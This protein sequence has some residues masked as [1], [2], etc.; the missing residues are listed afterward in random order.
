MGGNQWY[1]RCW[2]VLDRRLKDARR[3]TTMLRVLLVAAFV[4]LILLLLRTVIGHSQPE[5]VISPQQ[6]FGGNVDT[7]ALPTAVISALGVY[8]NKND[9]A[10]SDVVLVTAANFAYLDILRN[11]QCAVKRL[12]LKYVVIAMDKEIYD[13]LGPETAVMM[14]GAQV[15]GVRQ[16]S[17][18]KIASVHKLL[19]AGVDVLFSDPDNVLLQDPFR[20]GAEVGDFIRGGRIDYVYQANLGDSNHFWHAQWVSAYQAVQRL[21][22]CEQQAEEE[23]NTGFYYAR[24]S[25]KVLKAVFRS[26]MDRCVAQPTISDQTHFWNALNDK[27]IESKHCKKREVGGPWFLGLD[28]KLQVTPASLVSGDTTLSYCCMDPR[29]Y[30]TGRDVRSSTNI[31]VFHANFATRKSDAIRKLRD[32]VRGGAWWGDGSGSDLPELTNTQQ[33]INCPW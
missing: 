17:C 19:K 33:K 27:T 8:A 26:T 9:P 24:A 6:L 31:E 12:G 14:S 4:W 13:L 10:F 23:G 30:V 28:S 2:M 20:P 3:R 7:A 32:Y 18:G 15:S 22:R 29:V 25:S 5:L 1:V 16:A 11:W 21:T